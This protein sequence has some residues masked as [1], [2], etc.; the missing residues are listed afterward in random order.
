MFQCS[1]LRLDSSKNGLSGENI[2]LVGMSVQGLTPE[3]CNLLSI[4]FNFL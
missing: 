3:R 2:W 1:V 4:L